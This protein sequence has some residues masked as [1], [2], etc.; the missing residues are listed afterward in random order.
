M[1]G[2]ALEGEILLLPK[3]TSLKRVLYSFL[4]LG[5]SARLLL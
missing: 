5:K 2:E 1:D 3:R 4:L